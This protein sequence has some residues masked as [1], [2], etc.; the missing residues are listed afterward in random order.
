[1]PLKWNKRF[2]SRE[3]L[4]DQIA[5][6]QVRRKNAEER[7]RYWRKNTTAKPWWSMNQSNRGT[8]TV[9]ELTKPF[10]R[11]LTT[12][13]S[14]QRRNFKGNWKRFEL[15]VV[16]N[17]RLQITKKRC[18]LFFFLCIKYRY[19]FQL[20]LVIEK[21]SKLEHYRLLRKSQLNVNASDCS[22]LFVLICHL[23]T[24]VARHGSSYRGSKFYKERTEGNANFFELAGG[25][26]HRGR[27]CNKFMTEIQGKSNLVR[28]SSATF[29]L[30]RVR[31]IGNRT[32]FI[33]LWMSCDQLFICILTTSFKIY[34]L[35]YIWWLRQSCLC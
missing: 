2:L 7:D 23:V 25:S 31:V 28:R 33:P 22:T 27:N 16:E 20:N 12:V 3:D 5:Q 29:E 26:S 15:L 34:L 24:D 6:E 11:L 30:A 10:I 1:M 21:T 4:V 19:T 8:Y 32:Y 13:E 9:C 17:K 14:A 35:S 18:L